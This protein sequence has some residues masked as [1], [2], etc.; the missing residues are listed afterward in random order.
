MAASSIP[1][2]SSSGEQKHPSCILTEGIFHVAFE[3][4]RRAE[5]TISQPCDKGRR[6]LASEQI[7]ERTLLL[8]GSD[9]I[10]KSGLLVLRSGE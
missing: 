1:K 6:L 9:G 2:K 4:R 7:E 3:S 5:L 10:F 8:K